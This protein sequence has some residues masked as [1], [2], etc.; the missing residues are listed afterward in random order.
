[1][2]SRLSWAKGM[3]TGTEECEMVMMGPKTPGGTFDKVK[4]ERRSSVGKG[5]G[6]VAEIM[7]R[8]EGSVE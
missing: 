2:A 3:E 1:M 7:E 8:R 6:G 5:S 4:S